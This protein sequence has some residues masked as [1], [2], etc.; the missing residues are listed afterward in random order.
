MPPHPR[1]LAVASS[2]RT[3]L[4][5]FLASTVSLLLA[6]LAPFPG[7]C[8][9]RYQPGLSQTC[10]LEDVPDSNIATCPNNPR[11]PCRSTEGAVY[12][13]HILTRS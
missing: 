1:T 13:P 4:V 8:L 11:L 3:S 12:A 10:C 5:L 9:L 2:H 7:P 6:Q